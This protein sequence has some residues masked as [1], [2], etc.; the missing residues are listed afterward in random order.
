MVI[1]DDNDEDYLRGL[2]YVPC[3]CDVMYLVHRFH[4]W[5]MCSRWQTW[6]SCEHWWKRA[7]KV[8]SFNQYTYRVFVTVVH[9]C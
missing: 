4:H 3:S 1:S 7:F 6:V 8:M 5:E 2:Q 9:I